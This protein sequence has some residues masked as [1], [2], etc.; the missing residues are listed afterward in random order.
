MSATNAHLA[1]F[2]DLD[3]ATDAI[4]K[5]RE[6]GIS[7]QDITVV[8]GVPYSHQM[9]DRPTIP[10]SVLTL[11]GM[12]AIGGFLIGIALNWGAPFLYPLRVGGL[13]LYPIPTTL[14]LTFETTMLGLLIFTFL[15][16]LWENGFPLIGPKEYHPEISD[17]KIALVFNCPPE[18]F[19]KIHKSLTD[20]G[21]EL[22]QR[23]EAQAL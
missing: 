9:L 22:V 2:G 8:S 11:G 19:E 15:G 17:G 10:T 23:T 13:P 21:A 3:P 6:F 4:V 12:G 20:L 5:L 1:L 14:V 16:V 7:D 18:K